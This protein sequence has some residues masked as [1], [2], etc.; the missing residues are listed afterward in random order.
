M[1]R[2]LSVV[3]LGASLAGLTGCNPPPAKPVQEKPAATEPA[4]D[5][6]SQT[7]PQDAGSQTK[8]E[9]APKSGSGTK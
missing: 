9:A 4:K 1:R 5:A 2:V 7:K 8:P 3:I 6:G